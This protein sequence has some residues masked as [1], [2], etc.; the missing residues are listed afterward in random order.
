MKSEYWKYFEQSE[1]ITFILLLTSVSSMLLNQLENSIGQEQQE[2]KVEHKSTISIVNF[3]YPLNSTINLGVPFLIQYDNTTSV[4]SLGSASLDNFIITF[5]GRGILNGT[6][7][8]DDNGTGIFLTNHADGTVYQKGVIELRIENSSESIKT[9][10][11]SLGIPIRQQNPDKHLL[12]D[13]GAMFF[14]TSSA[15]DG[16]LSFLNNKVGIY[17]DLLDRDMLNLTTFAWEWN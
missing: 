10:Y 17:K 6:L 14:N 16:K 15:E 9:T 13:S 2:A 7:K 12:L 5:A 11:E 1:F 3:S 4:K 8:Y